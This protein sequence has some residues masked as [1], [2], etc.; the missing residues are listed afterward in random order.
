MEGKP[1]KDENGTKAMM[2]QTTAQKSH[3]NYHGRCDFVLSQAPTIHA[4]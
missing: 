4:P 2:W 1:I 3:E